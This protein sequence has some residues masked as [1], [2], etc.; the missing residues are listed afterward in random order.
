MEFCFGI[1]LVMQNENEIKSL[2]GDYTNLHV[3]QWHSTTHIP[4]KASV[5]VL[6]LPHSYEPCN[7]WEEL[8]G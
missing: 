2:V 8:T 6:T 4:H 1:D 5:M 3:T 7:R